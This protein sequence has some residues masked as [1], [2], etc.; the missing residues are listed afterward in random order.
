MPVNYQPISPVTH[1][2]AGWKR[3]SRYFYAAHDVVVPVGCYRVGR[4]FP[5]QIVPSST[6][7]LRNHGTRGT[8]MNLITFA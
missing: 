8:A 7:F 6:P 1:R 3:P 2:D 5:R 4:Q